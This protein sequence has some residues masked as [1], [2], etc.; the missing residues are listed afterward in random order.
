MAGAELVAEAVVIL[1]PRVG[2]FDQ[3]R[4]R[5]AGGQL[6]V[7]A[8]VQEHAGENAH[9]VCFLALA[10]KFRLARTAAVEIGLDIGL[11]Q[12]NSGRAAIHHATQSRPVAFAE[13]SDAE[14][15][16]ETVM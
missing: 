2:I 12:R 1:R 11:D 8:L 9:T 14:K 15:M 5:R 13:G 3:K 6:L 10:D 16:T 7:H 4:D